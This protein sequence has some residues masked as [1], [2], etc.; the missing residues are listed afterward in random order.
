MVLRKVKQ[1]AGPHERW[2]K[3]LKTKLSSRGTTRIES[4]QIRGFS[5]WIGGRL[6]H[7][8]D[9]QRHSREELENNSRKPR[10]LAE[11]RHSDILQQSSTYSFSGSGGEGR[12]CCSWWCQ[13]WVRT[14]QCQSQVDMT[15]IQGT[16]EPCSELRIC[17]GQLWPKKGD[18]GWFSPY[19]SQVEKRVQD[20]DGQPDT[21]GG[22]SWIPASHTATVFPKNYTIFCDLGR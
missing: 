12:W 11:N 7:V 19:T 9:G 16:E 22:G 2:S 10:H 15:A 8:N 18:R 5:W 6:H 1:E 3:A 17:I 20:K 14:T 21:L 4:T 13:W